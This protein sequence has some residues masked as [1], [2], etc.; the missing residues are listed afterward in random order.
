M[1]IIF[2]FIIGFALLCS[3][4][5]KAQVNY[6]HFVLAG[7]IDLSE[8]RFLEAI[9]NFN[10]A[11][12]YKS[13]HFEAYFLRGVAKFSLSDYQGAF[14]DFSKTL[15]I[16][17]LYVRAW[18]YRGI[19]NDRLSN[20]FDAKAD[21][22]RALEIDPYDADLHLAIGATNMHMNDFGEAI[23]SYDMAL[24]IN[25]NMSNAYLNRGVANRLLE[26]LGEAL[27]D[28]DKAV[29]HD[30]FNTEAWMRR[31]MIQLELEAPDKALK[32]FNEAL[33]LDEQNPLLYFQRA[34][35]YLN[36]GD[37][38]AA[39]QDY[40]TVNRLDSRN[41]L[42][43]YN[44]ALIHSLQ[45]DYEKALPLYEVV[46]KINPKNVYAW[47][48]KG[49][50]HFQL[51]EFEDAAVDFSRAID[52]FPD[53]AGAWINRS[54]AREK[55]G[56]RKGSRA[57]YEQAMSIIKALNNEGGNPDSLY[58]R[59]ADSTYFDQIF[60]LESDFVSGEA[61]QS[62]VQFRQIDIV[63]FG[64]LSIVP[65]EEFPPGKKKTYGT[66]IDLGLS[67]LNTAIH[68]G[69][70]LAFA[71]DEHVF[72]KVIGD[73][74]I[75]GKYNLPNDFL[76]GIRYQHQ[77]NYNK[78][79]NAYTHLSGQ[80]DWELY[81]LTNLVNVMIEKAELVLAEEQFDQALMITRQK[82]LPTSETKVEVPDYS[83]S[84]MLMQQI[85]LNYPDFA[86]GWYN[87][88]NIHMQNRDF[89]P[90]I[91]AYS[92]AIRYEPNL[93]EAYY[94]RALTLLYLGEQ[95]LACNDLSKAGELGLEEAYAVI[96]RYCK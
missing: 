25:P 48:N 62:R 31:G 71:E 63:P 55:S 21:F 6:R 94:N 26:R 53:F 18:H 96:K 72:L 43:Y 70:R 23:K 52:L 9:Q 80:K 93:A 49:V 29:Y 32:D 89:H 65:V 22:A 60:A 24:L 33:R 47:F 91:D 30:Y 12:R 74:L 34:M 27:E 40:E 46:T 81:A 61:Q 51:D 82:H 66:Y 19:T 41:A 10:T 50:T 13:D 78:A 36:M 35:A 37:T 85:L 58:A 59:Y 87:M 7:R 17:P 95:E 54:V 11:L 5:S 20:Y 75:E 73:S 90:A 4:S 86:F 44:R 2:N 14:E 45:K 28:L 3:L 88:G 15:E 56:D 84:R 39:M 69:F 79:I 64:L 67:Q 42:T 68:A 57:D 8:E 77:G 76:L 83:E 38:T 1:R 16:H 92:E